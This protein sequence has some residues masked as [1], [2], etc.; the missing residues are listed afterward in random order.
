VFRLALLVPLAACTRT[1]DVGSSALVMEDGTRIAVDTIVP[2][3]REGPV[4]AVIIQ[5]RYWRSFELKVRR[6]ADAMPIQPREDLAKE[7]L[8]AG[9]GVVLVDVRG[10]GASEGTW[11][12]PWSPDEVADMAEIVE[13]VAAMPWCDGRVGATGVSYEGTTALLAASHE[14]PALRAVLAREIEWDLV[15]E[16]LAPGGVR[17]VS[18]PQQWSRAVVDLDRGEVPEFWGASAWMI[19]GPRP[20]DS[21][22]DGVDLARVLAARATPTVAADVAG[23]RGPGDPWGGEGGPPASTVGPS[24]AEEALASSEAAIGVWGSWWDGATADAVLRADAALRVVDARI[25]GWTHEG[26]HSA[27][28]LGRKGDRDAR[29]DLAEVVEF[30]DTWL[31]SD[32]GRPVRAHWVAGAERWE[33]GEEWPTTSLR[34][35]HLRGDGALGAPDPG[36]RRTLDVDFAATV[37]DE[38]RWTTGMLTNVESPDRAEAPGLLSFAAP[39][40]GPLR[41]FG[42]GNLRC[43][44]SLAAPE[45]AMHVYLEVIEPSGRVRL[46]TEGLQRVTSGPVEVPL[47]AVAADLPGD[48]GLR[49]SFAG[50]DAGTFE[51]VPAQGPQRITVQGAGCALT[52]PVR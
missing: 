3:D 35:W 33:R 18:F 39:G 25:G 9:F 15:D 32:G 45:A 17:N 29:V 52:L 47:R 36:L 4:P 28:P 46:L 22:P 27:S 7:L 43:D 11:G 51:R 2:P 26:N 34:T 38:T 37:G 40:A 30:F 5:T 10:T 19:R 8:A 42:A 48:H 14:Q 16:L 49:L 12:R 6:P 44:V 41:V 13:Q 1:Y 20:L 31:T 21:D 23:I 50:A 24:G